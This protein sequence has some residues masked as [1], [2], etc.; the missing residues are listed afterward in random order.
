MVVGFYPKNSNGRKGS[1]KPHILEIL[2]LSIYLSFCENILE[3]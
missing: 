1:A 2:A 3:T